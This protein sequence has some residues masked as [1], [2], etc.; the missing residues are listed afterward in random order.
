MENKV[1]NDFL[2]FINLEE[3]SGHSFYDPFRL[4]EV[5]EKDYTR[6]HIKGYIDYAITAYIDNDINADKAVHYRKKLESDNDFYNQCA[7]AV[8]AEAVKQRDEARAER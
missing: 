5:E 1:L 6:E 2:T 4:D 3:Q 7:D 8:L